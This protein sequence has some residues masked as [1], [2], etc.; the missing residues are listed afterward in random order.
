MK[1]S[2]RHVI[3]AAVVSA[4][5][6]MAVASTGKLVSAD[7]G[8]RNYLTFSRA[9]ALPGSVL[10]GGLYKFEVVSLDPSAYVIE[11]RKPE[12]MSPVAVQV[13]SDNGRRV[14]FRGFTWRV[15]R[16]ADLP[17]DQVVSLGEARKGDPTPITAW[18]PVG[19][20]HGHKFV[21]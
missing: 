1:F 8:V 6:A 13:T 7:Y 15:P 14:H 4:L 21:W 10:P 2:R 19:E 9:V 11:F 18:Y 3:R 20:T 17:A 16:P 12:S 5:V